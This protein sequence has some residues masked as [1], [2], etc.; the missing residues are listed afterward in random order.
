MKE[1]ISS[2]KSIRSHIMGELLIRVVQSTDTRTQTFYRNVINRLEIRE[3]KEKR[4]ISVFI[5]IAMLNE[6]RCG[7]YC[8]MC[9]NDFTFRERE[10]SLLA[11]D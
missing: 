5:F 7:R 1:K 3:S 8:E 10:K 4:K 2:L 6:N 9:S 11:K